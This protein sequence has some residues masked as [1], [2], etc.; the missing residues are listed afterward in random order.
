M[1]YG[2]QHG[3]RFAHRQIKRLGGRVGAITL[4]DVVVSRIMVRVMDYSSQERRGGL[5]DLL[6]RRALISTFTPDGADMLV[7]PDKE[8]HRIVLYVPNTTTVESAL[9][10]LAKPLPIEVAGFVTMWDL[11]VLQT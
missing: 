8:T 7:V 10:M 11:Q 6:A 5:V 1:A 4:D 3:R 9:R 2:A